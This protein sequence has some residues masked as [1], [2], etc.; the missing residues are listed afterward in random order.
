[1]CAKASTTAFQGV[2]MG[3]VIAGSIARLPRKDV[4]AVC[5]Y[6]ISTLE[7][8]LVRA[9]AAGLV[10]QACLPRRKTRAVRSNHALFDVLF[11]Q[12]LVLHLPKVQL[13]QFAVGTLKRGV[14]WNPWQ[15]KCLTYFIGC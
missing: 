14:V 15:G 8:V 13:A 3:R 5:P 1:M 11:L 2:Q 4:L 6:S 9:S 12:Q 7:P 10:V